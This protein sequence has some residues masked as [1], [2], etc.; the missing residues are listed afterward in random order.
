ML[1]QAQQV[2]LSTRKSSGVI[3]SYIVISRVTVLLEYFVSFGA[4]MCVSFAL[5][6]GVEFFKNPNRM[7]NQ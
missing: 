4:C 3:M 6:I 5:R 2:S 1:E 7:L